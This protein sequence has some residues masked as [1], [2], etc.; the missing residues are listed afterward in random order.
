MTAIAHYGSAERVHLSVVI[1]VYGCAGCIEE[2]HKRL[3]VVLPGITRDYEIIL[4][5]DCSPDHSWPLLQKLAARDPRVIALLLSRNFGQHAAITAGLSQSRGDWTV[6]MDCDLQ[7]PPEEIPRLYREAMAGCDVVY[8]R[9]LEKQ[10]SLSR[11][12][13]ASVYFR[14]L[15]L[16]G[17]GTQPGVQGSFTL[18]S[19]AVVDAFLSMGDRDRHYLFI[20]RWLGFPSSEIEYEHAER[21]AGRSSYSLARLLGHAMAGVFFQ[22]TAILRWVVYVGFAL[23]FASF[24]L[25]V[26]FLYQYFM[27]DVP[28]GFTSLAVLI[29]LTGGIVTIGV[30]TVGLYV[31]RTFEQVKGRPLFVVARWESGRIGSTDAPHGAVREDDARRGKPEDAP[32]W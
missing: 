26:Y 11:R 29:L 32:Q 25:A 27:H 21:Y 22:T 1:P 15:R 4:V 7:D 30:G 8:T 6:V 18:I 13:A 3:S 19:R 23:A 12:S 20:L 2:L 16:L 24:V 5:D 9:R 31:G 17:G 10:H 28:P 14:V